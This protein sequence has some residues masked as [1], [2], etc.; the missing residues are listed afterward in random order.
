MRR[1]DDLIDEKDLLRESDR[2][3][4]SVIEDVLLNFMSTLRYFSKGIG[5]GNDLGLCVFWDNLD[6]TQ[7]K[8]CEPFD[9]VE[10]SDI[11][12]ERGVL[13]YEDFYYYLRVASN[14]YIQLYPQDAAEVEELLAAYRKRFNIGEKA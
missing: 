6:E 10:C 7:K 12:D 14:T 1:M 2:V 5:V 4:V 11:A 9:G 3:A 13:S 8:E